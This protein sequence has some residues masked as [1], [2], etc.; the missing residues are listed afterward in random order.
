MSED[1]AGRQIVGM[2]LHRRR[3]VLVRMT[4][5]G[6]R[7]ETV[8]IVNDPDRLAAVMARAGEAPEVVLEATY[9][10]YWAADTLAGLGA[11]VHLAHPLGVKAFAY[12]RV[13]NDERDA[14]DLCDLLRMGRLPEA[15]VAP[16]EVRGLR[17]AVRQRC[18]LVAIR[19]GRERGRS[20]ASSAAA[21]KA[22]VRPELAPSPPPRGES[23]ASETSKGGSSRA[24]AITPIRDV[25]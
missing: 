8:R 18:K 10:W 11:S 7:L 23:L 19:S 13:K 1:Y 20:N 4:E 14:A 16:P 21:R 25:S 22:T 9:G 24:E 6:E 2:D 5:A 15:W 12:R 3:S 17:E